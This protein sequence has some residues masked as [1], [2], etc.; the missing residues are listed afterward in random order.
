MPLATR[1]VRIK[2]LKGEPS[3]ALI[4]ANTA[5]QE[6]DQLYR[7]RNHSALAITRAIRVEVACCAVQIP[8]SINRNTLTELF[9]ENIVRLISLRTNIQTIGVS[10]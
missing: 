5:R 4:G 10:K 8:P 6:S 2:V 1:I 3:G 9:A 7:L